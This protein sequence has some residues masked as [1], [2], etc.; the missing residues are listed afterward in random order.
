[1]QFEARLFYMVQS[2]AR[3]PFSGEKEMLPHAGPCHNTS[4][5]GDTGIQEVGFDCW[6][7]LYYFNDDNN[8]EHFFMFLSNV[9]VSSL[10]DVYSNLLFLH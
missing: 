1:M 9:C 8:T 2:Y 4:L 5:D 7:Y 6:V 3:D 10:R